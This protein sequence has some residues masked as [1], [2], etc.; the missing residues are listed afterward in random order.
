MPCGNAYAL[1]CTVYLLE[2]CKSFACLVDSAAF[3]SLACRK[4]GL[5]MDKNE[6]MPDIE[7]IVGEAELEGV[8]LQ[9][10]G[11]SPGMMHNL[12]HRGTRVHSSYKLETDL[13]LLG[14]P[15][16]NYMTVGQAK[17]PISHL[18]EADMTNCQADVGLKDQPG[19]VFR[20]LCTPL[21]FSR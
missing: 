21:T 17:C 7:T 2:M 1:Q 15:A 11:F 16:P 13:V 4:D 20:H 5:Y 12:V 6:D 8:S 19:A 14:S 9:N 18:L 10:S 3:I